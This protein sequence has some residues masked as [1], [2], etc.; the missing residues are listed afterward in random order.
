[1][2]SDGN[3]MSG[4][5]V[6]RPVMVSWV[7]TTA[8]VLSRLIASNPSFEVAVAMSQAS[9]RSVAPEA[10][11]GACRASGEAPILTWLSTAPPFWA[12]PIMSSVVAP[13][14]SRWAAMP[15]SAPIVTTPVPPMPVTRMA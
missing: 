12:S 15:S 13:L 7:L 14:P 9:S 5:W 6:N 11:R 4:F 10:M 8:R 2:L 1:M 3:T